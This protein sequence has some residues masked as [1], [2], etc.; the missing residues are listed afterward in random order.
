MKDNTKIIESATPQ[1][2][3]EINR[4]L[5]LDC[6][7][8]Y[9]PVS[10]ADL[11]RCLNMSAPS[12]S[13]NVKRMLDDGYLQE[14]GDGD[15]PRGR[16]SMLLRFN[17][18]RSY[19]IGVDVGRSQIRVILAD[20]NGSEVVAL[21][22]NVDTVSSASDEVGAVLPGMLS[23]AVAKAGLENGRICCICIG[24]PGIPD[25]E[26]GEL[27]AAPFIHAP[28]LLKMRAT[29]SAAYPAAEIFMEN[30]VNYGAVGE[31][32][33][34]VAADY[35]NIVY[36]DYGVGIGAALI[37]NGELYRGARGAAG[38]IGYT[39]PE[40]VYFRD[41]F[42]VQGVLESLISGKRVGDVLR[43]RENGQES[44]GDLTA[45]EALH[46]R[47]IRAIVDYVGLMLI[48]ITAAFNEELIVL[49][50]R[51]GE[52]LGNAFIPAWSRMLEQH[53]PFP[54]EIRVSAL[55]GRADA[56][57]AVAVAIRHANDGAIS[58]ED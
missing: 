5:I 3:S 23:E 18:E 31:K 10:R 55:S 27:A 29:L 16:K 28:D 25:M 36:I 9:G 17:A 42:E 22:E 37:L 41:R 46:D 21:M 33:K 39:V 44:I 45:G 2:I 1:K 8:K 24:L 48:N 12:V 26:T 47:T 52:F 49:G 43:A 15:N 13:A 50:G 57:G 38:E 51:F 58:R 4:G 54:P 35:R 14:I 6:V 20:L 19:V 40:S 53:V 7:R 11:S 32:W 56:I 30:S 34:G